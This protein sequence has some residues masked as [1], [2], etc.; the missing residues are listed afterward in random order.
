[1]KFKGILTTVAIILTASLTPLASA[2]QVPIV[3]SFTFTPNELDL[4]SAET[5][6]KIELVVSHPAGISNTS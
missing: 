2:S 1:M 4:L 6:I 5:T 3:E